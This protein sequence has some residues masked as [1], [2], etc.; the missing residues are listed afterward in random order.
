M[1]LTLPTGHAVQAI[2]KRFQTIAMAMQRAERAAAAGG[3][4]AAAKQAARERER[5]EPPRRSGR[6]TQQV[7]FFDPA[8]ADKGGVADS[9][10]AALFGPAECAAVE[11]ATQSM[12]DLQKS[13]GG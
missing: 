3:S 10:L 2:E 7:E 12:L 6:A 9:G 13:A 1:F 5:A 11:A 4:G 8:A